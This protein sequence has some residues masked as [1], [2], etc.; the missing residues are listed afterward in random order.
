MNC[1]RSAFKL[2]LKHTPDALE[3]L[4]NKC[5]S[6]YCEKEQV[7]GKIFYDFFLFYPPEEDE[8]RE[9]SGELTMPQI[10]I[11][12]GKQHYLLHPIFETFMQVC[13]LKNS[14]NSYLGPEG[15]A[16]SLTDIGLQS[17]C[18]QPNY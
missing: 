18:Y 14:F 10:L 6:S 17:D 12:H 3:H 8:G 7:Q 9:D 15:A 11:S 2:L 5:I 16:L 13:F 1:P 4:F